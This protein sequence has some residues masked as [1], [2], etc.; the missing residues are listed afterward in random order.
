MSQ[1]WGTVAPGDLFDKVVGAAF[2]Q[3][4]REQGRRSSEDQFFMY[5]RVNTVGK[6]VP[7]AAQ[8]FIENLPAVFQVL[9]TRHC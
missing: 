4:G 5:L 1:E 9:L 2:R 6:L 8:R 3:L 7:H